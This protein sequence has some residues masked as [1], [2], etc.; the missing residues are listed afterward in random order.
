MI[1]VTGATGHL[2]QLVIEALLKTTPASDIV[3]AV[4]TPAKAEA[5]AAK[6]IQVREADYSRPET[7]TKAF[8]GVQ[9]V[10]LISGNEMGQRVAQHKAVIDAA[11]TA[12]VRLLAYTS[13]LH[14]DTSPLMLAPDHV[15]TEQYLQASGLHFTLLRNGWYF[16]NQTVAIAPSL[17]HGA[18]IGA[19]GEGRFAAASRADY[20]AAAAEVLTGNGHENRIYELAGDTSYTRADLAAEVSKQ[21]GKTI[22]YHDLPEAEYAKILSAFLPSELAHALANCDT[23]AKDGVLDDTSHT[24][25]KLTGHPTTTLAEAVQAAL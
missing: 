8:E 21:T 16:E 23:L 14:A 2:G 15:A 3:A 1:A 24:L 12:N 17:Q 9:R 20:A 5:L 6:G 13:L 11:K 7:L 19:S 10:L 4:R 22:P 18:M 25:S